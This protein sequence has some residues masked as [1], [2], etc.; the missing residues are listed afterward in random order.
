MVIAGIESVRDITDRKLAELQLRR[1][2]AAIEASMDGIAILT[3]KEEYL[4][5]NEAHSAVYGYESPAELIGKSWHVLYDE[6][7]RQ[8][9]EPLIFEGFKANSGW[10]GE[11]TGLKKNGSKFAQEISLTLLDEGGLICVVRDISERKRSE[12][13]IRL[14][15]ENLQQQTRILQAANRDLEA[16]GYSLSHDLRA[17]LSRIYMAVQAIDMCGD[18]FNETDRIFLQAIFK[19]CECMEEFI[20]AMLVLFRVTQSEIRCC[21]VDLSSLAGEIMAGLQLQQTERR[22]ELVIMPGLVATCDEQLARILL[23]N[24]FGN[25][26]KYTSRVE[27]SR[28][29]FGIVEGNGISVFFVRDNG[30]GFDMAE[31]GRLFKP[32]QRLHSL[33]EFPGTGVGLAT[34]LRIVERHGGSIWSEGVVDGGATFYFTLGRSESST[35]NPLF[36]ELPGEQQKLTSP[37]LE[38]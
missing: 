35:K 36:F 25:A 33:G 19:G 16:F 6:Q 10:R 14:L 7:E 23:E 34:V 2:L 11:A 15:N 18:K 37:G 17:P 29:E 38:L 12:E 8:R 4:Y 32:F 27:S 20:N 21:D 22:V 28:I 5:L 13:A 3:A 31:A 1:Q 26:W 30:A 24:L 9:L